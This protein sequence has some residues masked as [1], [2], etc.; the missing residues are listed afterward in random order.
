LQGFAR[1]PGV[2]KSRSMRGVA[3]QRSNMR[4]TPQCDDHVMHRRQFLRFG[5]LPLVGLAATSSPARAAVEEATWLDGAR[6]RSLPLLMRWPGGDEP[7]ALVL[8]SHGLGGNREGGDAW[9]R[10]W[11]AAGVAVLHLQ[12]PGSD[13]D[14]LRSG[15]MRAL[16]AAASGEQLL[17]RVA[18]MRFAIDELTRRAQRG[19]PGWSRLRLDALGAS[20][21]SFG[22]ATVLALAGQD[23]AVRVP[24]LVE[25]RFKAFLALSP[26]PGRLQ[27]AFAGVR[28]PMLLATG[29]LDADALG[30]GLSGAD[31]A[32]VYEQLPAGERRL[33]WLDGADHMTFAGNATQPLRARIGPLKREPIA[34]E[35]EAQHHHRIATV[36]TLWWRAQLQGDAAAVAALRFPAGLGPQDRW[37]S[38]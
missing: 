16:R 17:A 14:V 22:A 35:L 10:A 13:T 15:G 23:F 25:P 31:R 28:R 18:D 12:H 1:L 38:D 11:Q 26:A 8:H 2:K 36:S 30:R 33:L 19:E 7:C 4:F 6:G 24:S 34:A 27:N 3:V 21:H 32:S 9:G 20:G 37:R 5:G 29:S